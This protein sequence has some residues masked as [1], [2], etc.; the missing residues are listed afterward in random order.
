[1]K[2]VMRFLLVAFMAVAIS[3]CGGSDN[4]GGG[5][6]D[7]PQEVDKVTMQTM[8][9]EWELTQWSVS[10][11]VFDDSHKIYMRLTADGKFDLYQVNIN[12]AG[13]EYLKGTFTFDEQTQIAKGKYSDGENWAAKDGYKV[14]QPNTENMKW[15]VVGTTES[16][17]FKKCTIP[18][19][20]IERSQLS[21]SV[22][23]IEA[24]RFL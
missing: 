8:A 4:N 13:V 24:F 12:V 11:E 14:E 6:G 2:N 17:T 15:T 7:N 1:M 22:R 23:S 3:S 10:G 9:G 19:D 18:A 21:E 5:G 16:N 20:V